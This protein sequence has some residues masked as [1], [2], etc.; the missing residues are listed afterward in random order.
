MNDKRYQLYKRFISAHRRK[1]VMKSLSFKAVC[2]LCLSLMGGLFLNAGVTQEKKFPEATIKAAYIYNLVNF[3]EWPIDD[4][5]LNI[6][7]YGNTKYYESAFSSMSALSKTGK[8]LKIKYMDVDILMDKEICQVVFISHVAVNSTQKILSQ[9]K[10]SP[11]LT[12]GES[13][14]FLE[15]G[16]MINFIH[17]ANKI[18][19][20]INIKA[21]EKAELRISSKVLRIADRLITDD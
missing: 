14:K 13:D 3:V 17:K 19:F 18:R 6:C 4:M 8:V 1:P 20:E 2:I 21:Y 12:I 9:V 11:S 10:D 15:K 16:G 7:I 5:L